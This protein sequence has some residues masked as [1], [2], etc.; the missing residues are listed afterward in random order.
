MNKEKFVGKYLESLLGDG[1]IKDHLKDRPEGERKLLEGYLRGSLERSY[2]SY[3]KNYFD[4]KGLGSY[5]STLLRYGGAVADAIGTYMFWA[6]GGA[7]LGVKGLGLLEKSVADTI[8]AAHYAK[9]A[10]SPLVEK[11]A[12]EGKALGEGIAERAAAYLPLGAGEL[13][14]LLRGRKKFDDKVLGR[15]VNYARKDF[16]DYLIKADEKEPYIVPLEKFRNPD[17]AGES[18]LAA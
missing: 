5:V 6:L 13:A 3:A 16:M 11:I 10:E 7:G 15:A 18:A 1:E 9:Y 17:Y 8:D 2:Q 4:S 12:D 14:D